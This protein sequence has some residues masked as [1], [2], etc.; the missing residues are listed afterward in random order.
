MR[1]PDLGHNGPYCH[2]ADPVQ[3]ILWRVVVYES[4]K[5]ARFGTFRELTKVGFS[6]GDDGITI[7][8]I[9]GTGCAINTGSGADVNC[10]RS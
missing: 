6:Q 3:T 1:F 10:P 8:G 9:P 4:P 5:V 7:H 2:R